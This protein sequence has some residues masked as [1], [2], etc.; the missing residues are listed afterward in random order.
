MLNARL[1]SVFLAASL[2]PIS[3]SEGGSGRR[4][5]LE[6]SILQDTVTSG[7]SELTCS[8]IISNHTSDDT[9]ALL[10]TVSSLGR[11]PISTTGFKH[12]STCWVLTIKKQR[13]DGVGAERYKFVN[14]FFFPHPRPPSENRYFLLYPDSSHHFCFR[15][16]LS[17]VYRSRSLS[18]RR[19]REYGTYRLT[20][21]YYDRF[22]VHKKSLQGILE[23]SPQWVEYVSVDS[24]KDEE[25]CE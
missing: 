25:A 19:N 15:I 23:S 6:F 8:V 3:Y 5:A 12:A 20:M 7:N 11:P 22:K 21:A 9:V 13:G 14:D 24:S 10:G 16:L 17:N 18:R 1:F 4:I 2:F